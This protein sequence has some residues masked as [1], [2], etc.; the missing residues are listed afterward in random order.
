[1]YRFPNVFKITVTISEL[2]GRVA[3]S[4][5]FICAMGMCAAAQESSSSIG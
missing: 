5:F 3:L 1:M 4:C 2:R